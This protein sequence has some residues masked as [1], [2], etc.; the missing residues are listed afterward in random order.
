MSENGGLL[1][2]ICCGPCGGGCVNRP[3]MISPERPVTLFYSNS[4][5]D[6]FEEFE[7]KIE[8]AKSLMEGEEIGKNRKYHIQSIRNDQ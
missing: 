5:L 6:S 1:L 7:R 4:N 2:H 8:Q 3:E